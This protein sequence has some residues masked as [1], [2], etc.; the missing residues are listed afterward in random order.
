[1][2][3]RGRNLPGTSTIQFTLAEP[4]ARVA[5]GLEEGYVGF[6]CVAEGWGRTRC[7]IRFSDETTAYTLLPPDE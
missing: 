7:Q 4:T 5:Y 3:E 1:M 6:A 2:V